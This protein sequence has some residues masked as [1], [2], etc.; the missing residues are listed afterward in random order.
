VGKLGFNMLVIDW[1]GVFGHQFL[2]VPE[3]HDTNVVLTAQLSGYIEVLASLGRVMRV[4]I[5]IMHEATA[6]SDFIF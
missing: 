3:H 1:E 4:G 5:D 2:V 6:A